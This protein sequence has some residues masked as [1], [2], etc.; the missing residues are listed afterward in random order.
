M[1]ALKEDYANARILIV[2]DNSSNVYLL[3]RVLKRRGYNNVDSE[4]DSRKVRQLYL[5]NRYDLILLDIR[6]PYL[7]GYEVIGQLKEVVGD[8]YLP[9]LVITAQTDDDTRKRAIESGAKDFLTKPFDA[10]EALNRVHNMLEVR[11]LH[12]QLVST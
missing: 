5:D 7:D 9:I 4:T 11:L 10:S 3:E 6:M 2:D 8:D 12:N 1:T